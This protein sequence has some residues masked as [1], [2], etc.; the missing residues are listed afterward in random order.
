MK[1][2]ALGKLQMRS[3]RVETADRILASCTLTLPPNGALRLAALD[4]DTV[5]TGF[6]QQNSASDET[7]GPNEEVITSYI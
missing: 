4:D 1:F 7:I 2:G 3:R 5:W 6:K